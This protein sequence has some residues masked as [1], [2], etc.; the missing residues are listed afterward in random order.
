MSLVVGEWRTLAS[1][2]CS[3]WAGYLELPTKERLGRGT[4]LDTSGANATK[5]WNDL[6]TSFSPL[7]LC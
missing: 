2:A 1:L 4:D 7:I 6:Q 5:C 3:V